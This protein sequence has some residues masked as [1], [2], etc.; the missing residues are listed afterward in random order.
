MAKKKTKKK[1][2][3]KKTAKK[4]ETK[5][6]KEVKEKEEK[7]KEIIKSFFARERV[8]TEATDEARNLYNKSA[9]ISY[10]LLYLLV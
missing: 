1:T 6:D 7:K 3:K 9:Y 4:K 8:I 10:I 5:V 2:T